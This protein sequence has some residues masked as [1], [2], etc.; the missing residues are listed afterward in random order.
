MPRP[1][2][3]FGQDV[4]CPTSAAPVAGG[5]LNLGTHSPALAEHE[6]GPRHSRPAI[7][8]RRLF[9]AEKFVYRTAGLPV[10]LRI[11]TSRLQNCPLDR[12]FVREFWR[13]RHVN[14]WLE[15][16]AAAVLLPL[17]FPATLLATTARYGPAIRKREGRSIVRQLRD[18]LFLYASS[19]ILPP[20]YYLFEL[21]RDP[22]KA[23]GQ[24]YLNRFQ[25]HGGV[26]LLTRGPTPTPLNDKKDF[27]DHCAASGIRHVPYL[28]CFD[29][30]EVGGPL[31]GT[32]LF[33]KPAKARGGKGAQR[34]AFL[35]EGLFTNSS[36]QQLGERPLRDRLHR[37]AATK[38]LLV[39]PRIWVHDELENLSNGALSTVRVVTCL[40]EFGDPEVVEALFR[41]AQGRHSIVDNFHAGGLA[42][43]VS[44]DD[45][46]L[47]KASGQDCRTGWVTSHPDTNAPI[48]GVRLPLWEETKAL[49]IEAH[50]AF[51]DRKI[52]G[53]DI[54]ITNEGPIIVEGNSS[55]DLDM[56][57]RV[58]RRGLRPSRLA[59]LLAFHVG[60]RLGT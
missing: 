17:T 2:A 55:P 22:S 23:V 31:P 36:Q 41:M 49:A 26:Y 29:G 47:D 52:I 60:T 4:P 3:G 54:A 33:V 15:L 57:Q 7:S 59:D 12:A 19:G 58:R 6:Q 1:Q 18:Q 30:S 40:N 37:E 45:G 46:R 24:S 51:A 43:A 48:E 9:R 50:H 13:P 56:H 21:H 27:A 39:Q 5:P 42:S 44:L 35:G 25:T 11:A 28:L 14:Q 32:D 8:R 38:P 53:W 34:W 10:A 20:W 16:V